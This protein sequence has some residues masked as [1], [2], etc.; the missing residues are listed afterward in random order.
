MEVAKAWMLPQT[1]ELLPEGEADEAG[2]GAASFEVHAG[3]T[4]EAS[5]GVV[6]VGVICRRS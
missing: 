2:V 4:V 6:P 1:L 3:V 5:I